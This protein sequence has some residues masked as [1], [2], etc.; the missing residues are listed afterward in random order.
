[1]LS[2]DMLASPLR[3]CADADP[4]DGFGL[5]ALKVPLSPEIHEELLLLSPLSGSNDGLSSPSVVSRAGRGERGGRPPAGRRGAG[6]RRRF[7]FGAQEAG[8]AGLGAPA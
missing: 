3:L 5:P 8:P 4:A 7:L 2:Y 1:M 6:R